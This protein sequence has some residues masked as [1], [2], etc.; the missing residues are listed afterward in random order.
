[1]KTL[2]IIGMA[3]M[4]IMLTLVVT[5]CSDDDGNDS[6]GDNNNL[7]GTK[8][9]VTQA[10]GWEWYENSLGN[11]FEFSSGGN[12][13]WW[14]SEDDMKE[15]DFVKRFR[16]KLDGNKLTILQLNPDGFT[17]QDYDNMQGKFTITGKTAIYEGV[18]EYDERCGEYDEYY[19]D[20]RCNF[21][22][23]FEKL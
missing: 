20:A 9:K 12:G 11:I 7:A 16:W 14:E 3:F 8:W 18:G 15:G 17:I 4:A 2:K 10:A 21:T 6:K 23:H 13:V 19:Y 5:S 1:M 22:V